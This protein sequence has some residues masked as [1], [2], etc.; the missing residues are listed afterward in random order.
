MTQVGGSDKLPALRVTIVGSSGTG[1]TT[2]MNRV[3]QLSAPALRD[4]ETGHAL[5]VDRC[6]NQV[7]VAPP[8]VGID[9][10]TY[11]TLVADEPDPSLIRRRPLSV[12]IWDTS[13]QERYRAVTQAYLR[14]CDAIVFMYDATDKNSWIAIKEF[15][16]PTTNMQITSERER[17]N[18]PK[19]TP[20]ETK[21]PPLFLLIENKSDLA[22]K[23][24]LSSKLP[25]I[26]QTAIEYGMEFSS[27]SGLCE[28]TETVRTFRDDLA[29][30]LWLNPYVRERRLEAMRMNGNSHRSVSSLRVSGITSR[31]PPANEKTPCCD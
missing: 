9:F 28:E 25:E 11:G 4:L 29:Q 3:V 31:P 24:P 23:R 26:R 5:A 15:W 22:G 16:L 21:R 1:K 17:M 27:L 8:T 6:S 20:P 12:Q 19:D 14:Q 10:I 2:F 7:N 13:G 30:R 18:P